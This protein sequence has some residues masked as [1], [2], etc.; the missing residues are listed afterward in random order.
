[1]LLSANAGS[2]A[3]SFRRRCGKTFWP[4]PDFSEPTPE[5]HAE[6]ARIRRLYGDANEESFGSVL[7]DVPC[8]DSGLAY[9]LVLRPA[10]LFAMT[11]GYYFVPVVDTGLVAKIGAW[12]TMAPWSRPTS[13]GPWPTMRRSAPA[14]RI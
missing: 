10:G 7:R 8:G 11:T 4:A 3:S 13:W 6:L 12:S 2:L 5:E 14:T 9:D 1:M